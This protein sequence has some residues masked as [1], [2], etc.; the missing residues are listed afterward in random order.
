[1]QKVTITYLADDEFDRLE[2]KR[3]LSV[4]D[5][6]MA[7]GEIINQVFRP[8]RKHGYADKAL[9]DLCEQDAVVEAI[10]LLEEK[11]HAILHEHN[12]SLD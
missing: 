11:F 5:V 2:A 7:L 12:V 4:T 8:A 10:G 6:Y 1:M 9:R 3:A